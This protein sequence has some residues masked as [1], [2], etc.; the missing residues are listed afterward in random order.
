MHLFELEEPP[1]HSDYRARQGRKGGGVGFLWR[2]NLHLQ[3]PD[4]KCS[5]HPQV[6]GD[7]MGRPVAVRVVYLVVNNKCGKENAQLLDCVRKDARQ[8]ANH[9]ELI[10]LGDFNG[11]LSDLDGHTDF[12]GM[13]VLR[14][15]EDLNVD[16]RCVG[17]F[18]WCAQESAITIDYALISHGLDDACRAYTVD[19]E[20]LGSVGSDH[21]HLCLG[22]KGSKGSCSGTG[23]SAS[24]CLAPQW[25]RYVKTWR[26][27]QVGTPQHHTRTS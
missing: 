17:R 18:K 4:G 9:R 3:R 15:A 10:V 13:L 5:E 21:N 26:S 1:A 8:W 12:N 7:L 20:G 2:R 6:C 22:W 11:H 27:A 19:E 25:R 23:L 14:L 16:Q 24:S